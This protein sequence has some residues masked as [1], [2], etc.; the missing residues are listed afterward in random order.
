MESY[1]ESGKETFFNTKLI[2]DGVIRNLEIIGEATK[3]ISKELRD[4]YLDIPM[5]KDGWTKRCFSS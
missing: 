3:N 4:G 5:E 1:T 2:Q